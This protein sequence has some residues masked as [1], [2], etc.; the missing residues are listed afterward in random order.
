MAYIGM[1]YIVMAYPGLAYII[2]A[3]IGM[4]YVGM[5]HIVMAYM[6]MAYVG[7]AYIVMTHIALAQPTNKLASTHSTETCDKPIA[8]FSAETKPLPHPSLPHPFKTQN[9]RLG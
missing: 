2:M 6:V 9:R 8:F 3:Y 1:A 4:A 7:M 5:A